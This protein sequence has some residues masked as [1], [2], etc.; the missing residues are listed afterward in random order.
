MQEDACCFLCAVAAAQ[1]IKHGG[2]GQLAREQFAEAHR[3]LLASLA[4][5]FQLRRDI[6]LLL[7]ELPGHILP[8]PKAR[9]GARL[10]CRRHTVTVFVFFCQSFYGARSSP[11]TARWDTAE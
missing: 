8:V 11:L 5:C 3:F 7:L 4:Q 10:L 1:Q 6:R 2:Y 9:K